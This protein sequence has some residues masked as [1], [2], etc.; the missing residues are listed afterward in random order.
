[1]EK[2][3][4]IDMGTNSLGWALVEMTEEGCVLLDRGV[5]IFQEGVAH[6]KSGE[7]PAVQDRTDARALRRHYFR[8]RL[9]KIALLR[10]LVQHDFCPPLSQE[11]LDAWRKQGVYPVTDEFIRWQRTDDAADKNP[12]RDRFRALTEELDLTRREDR[13]ALGRAL[14]HLCQRRG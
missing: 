10:V 11:Q 2:R 13:H 1:M 7:R 8:R 4:G 9:R 12:Y 14:Y 3:L 5:D 6:G